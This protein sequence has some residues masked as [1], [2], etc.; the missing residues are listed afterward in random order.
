[1]KVYTKLGILPHQQ[2]ESLHKI[3]YS[4]TP[5]IVNMGNI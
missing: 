5:T 3:R 4:A 1:M 2:N